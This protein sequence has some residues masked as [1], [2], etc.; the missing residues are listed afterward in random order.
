MLNKKTNK[1]I[2][3]VITMSKKKLINSSIS[4]VL[5][6][7]MCGNCLCSA[8]NISGEDGNI[9]KPVNSTDDHK[10][11]IDLAKTKSFRKEAQKQFEKMESDSNNIKICNIPLI[12][13]A[14]N[15]INDALSEDSDIIQPAT[16]Q[17]NH[18]IDMIL[19]KAKSFRR[20]AQKQFEKMNA[21]FNVNNIN[22]PGT[23]TNNA[24]FEDSD[25]IQPATF[26]KDYEI[27]MVL[28]RIEDNGKKLK[29]KSEK[30]KA[31]IALSNEKMNA[32][33]NANNINEPGTSTNNALLGDGSIVQPSNPLINHIIKMAVKET[34]EETKDIFAEITTNIKETQEKLEKTN[35]RIALGIE[36]MNAE[37]DLTH[38]E[39]E[40]TYNKSKELLEK[41]A[42]SKPI[43]N[44]PCFRMCKKG[45]IAVKVVLG[46]AVFCGCAYAIKCI[47]S[48]LKAKFSPMLHNQENLIKEKNS[49]LVR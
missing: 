43:E 24:L 7:A 48:K 32:D 41:L 38:K 28:H 33:F 40:A 3:G 11:D 20:E 16:F 23:S 49:S 29:E 21:D 15:N 34:M 47:F 25:I 35:A 44:R 8:F 2:R 45:K 27:D 37:A 10:I 14:I 5:S 1:N 30:R 46:T 9:E 17:S 39:I 4:L 18:E 36:K 6:I 22:E 19:A 42:Y 26:P 31:R 12:N 13:I